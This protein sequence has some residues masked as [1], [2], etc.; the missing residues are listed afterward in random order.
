[1]TISEIESKLLAEGCNRNQFA[2]GQRGAANDAYCLIQRDG[3]W[4]VFY[5]ERGEESSPIYSSASEEEACEFFFNHIL[6]LEHWHLVGWFVN[7]AEAIDFEKRIAA[8]GVKPI[9]NDIPFKSRKIDRFR[10][11]VMGKDIFPVK[12][13]IP[14][15]PLKQV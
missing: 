6:S 2:T 9:R 14:E 8:L 4:E 11:F 15:L 7:E 1:M 5:T 12:A 13:A 10:V 3:K